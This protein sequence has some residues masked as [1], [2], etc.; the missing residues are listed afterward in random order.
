[1]KGN[2]FL[3]AALLALGASSSSQLYVP[4]SASTRS[5]LPTRTIAGVTV[6]DTELVREAQEFAR[7]HSS[8]VVWNHVLRGWLFG[9]LI[10]AHN[11][12]LRATVDAEAHAVAA[13][14]HDLGW[15]QTPN[16]TTVSADRR[17]EVD[18]AI[19]A[20]EFIQ[21]HRASQQAWDDHRIQLVWDSIALHTQDSIYRYKEDTV[22]VTGAGILMD[23]NGPSWGV[24]Q[25]DYD[26][27]LAE[28][29][30]VQFREGINETFIWLCQTKPKTTIDTFIQPWGDNYVANYSSNG[31]RVFDTIFAL[32]P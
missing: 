29:P 26:A 17:F 31:S 28:V 23:F 10:I 5:T 21:S 4:S 3:R 9:S 16:S 11:D 27:V 25:Q 20:R 7:G 12:T 19:A 30:K 6:I 8:D 15:D 14:L 32:S 22:A 24:T 2:Y 1:M 13:I 18:G